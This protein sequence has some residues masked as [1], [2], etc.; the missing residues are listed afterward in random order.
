MSGR[1]PP[2]NQ[3][4]P[5]QVEV[6]TVTTDLAQTRPLSGS[7]T[8]LDAKSKDKTDPLDFTQRTGQGHLCC[9]TK[10]T[11]TGPFVHPTR[12]RKTFLFDSR[13]CIVH[14]CGREKSAT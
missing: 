9:S 13:V 2:A 10:S 6:Q 8:S 1:C 5:S 12:L 14:C 7:R 11:A 3:E 4:L